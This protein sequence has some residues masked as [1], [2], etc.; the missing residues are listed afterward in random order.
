MFNEYEERKSLNE[1][2]YNDYN[3]EQEKLKDKASC[4][5][6]SQKIP[7]TAIKNGLRMVA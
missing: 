5:I 7:L 1:S 6:N 4:L 3:Q 2:L